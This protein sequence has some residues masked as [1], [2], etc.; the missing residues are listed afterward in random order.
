MEPNHKQPPDDGRSPTDE[1]EE[2][3]STPEAILAKEVDLSELNDPI[4]NESMME[5]TAI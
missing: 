2:A 4:L 5:A 1:A 3:H